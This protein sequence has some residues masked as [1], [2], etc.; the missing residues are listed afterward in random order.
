MTSR[1][2]GGT[3]ARALAA[4][5][6]IEEEMKRI[7]YWD[8]APLPARAYDF[9]KAFGQDTMTFTQWLQFVLIPRVHQ[10]VQQQSEFPRSSMVGAQAIREF[11]GD[12]RADQLVR[13]LNEFDRLMEPN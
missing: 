4:I 6:G 12:D 10:V 8:E 7:G 9:H 1:T 5:D 2:P 13:M 3:Y 11:D